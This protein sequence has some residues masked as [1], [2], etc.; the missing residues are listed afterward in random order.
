MKG[1]PISRN[2]DAIGRLTALVAGDDN[3]LTTRQTIEGESRN[4]NNGE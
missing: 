2:I 3:D 1:D 4:E